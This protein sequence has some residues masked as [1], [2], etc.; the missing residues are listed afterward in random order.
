MD[1]RDTL[2]VIEYEWCPHD[3]VV[4]FMCTTCFKDL[5][6]YVAS[7]LHFDFIFAQMIQEILSDHNNF[8]PVDVVMGGPSDSPLR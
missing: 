3:M 8:L 6:E 4:N 5:S 2:C 1:F 7:S